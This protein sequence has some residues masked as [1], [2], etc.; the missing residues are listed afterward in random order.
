MFPQF[1]E[2]QACL[3]SGICDGCRRRL[4]SFDS[5]DPRP[6]PVLLAYSQMVTDLESLPA[7]TRNNPNCSCELCELASSHRSSSATPPTKYLR[8]TRADCSSIGEN[9]ENLLEVQVDC[10][11]R[12]AAFMQSKHAAQQ[13]AADPLSANQGT[14]GQHCGQ[15]VGQRM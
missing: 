2:Y 4:S 5:P 9:G 12:S 11:T 7:T 14:A 6:L 3:P 8:P 15:G 10:R 1:F 13:P